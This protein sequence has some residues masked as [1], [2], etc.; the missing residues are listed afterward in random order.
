LYREVRVQT[1][2]RGNGER[3]YWSIEDDDGA[4]QIP[5]VAADENQGEEDGTV[6]DTVITV[7]SADNSVNTQEDDVAAVEIVIDS[8]DE[9][10]VPVRK[11]PTR[12]VQID[13]SDESV[14]T[15]EDE[16][17]GAVIV[18][19]SDDE[20]SAPTGKAPTRAVAVDSSDESD[21]DADYIP[22]S[23][24]VSSDEEEGSSAVEAETSDTKNMEAR[25]P[26]AGERITPRPRKRNVR[27]A[28]AIVIDPDDDPY[29]SC[30]PQFE[31]PDRKR[32]RR[33]SPFVDSGVVMPP[34][35]ELRVRAP[36]HADDRIVRYINTPTEGLTIQGE[37]DIED[38]VPDTR[39]A[40]EKATYDT[41]EDPERTAPSPVPFIFRWRQPT[42]EALQRHLDTWCQACPSCVTGTDVERGM[43]RIEECRRADTVDI[44]ESTRITEEHIDKRGGFEGCDGC[45]R[46][47]MPRMICRRWRARPGGGG[48]EEVAEE[49]CQYEKRLTAAVIT[50][51]MDGCHEGWVTAEEWMADAKVRVSN[52]SEVL[53]WFREAVWWVDMAMEVSRM[54]CVFHMLAEENGK[55]MRR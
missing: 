33:E 45:G 46:C 51:L 44:V 38:R 10:L 23:E 3:R 16:V 28:S 6:D 43:H 1:W 8:D 53:E 52:E 5:E 14:G 40:A 49:A 47:G 26:T 55:I 54:V 50:M 37:P 21:G 13:S 34:S 48:W 32:Q 27:S 7:S 17:T 24:E 42:L 36:G 30:S 20:V 4:R 19:D 12:P 31:R 2:F 15:P 35:S 9:V 11:G 39:R 29:Q 22:S 25:Q 41:D 18:I